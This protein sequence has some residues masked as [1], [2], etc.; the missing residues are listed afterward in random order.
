MQ[1]DFRNRDLVGLG[2]QLQRGVAGLETIVPIAAP[3]K[4]PRDKVALGE[5]SVP[6][7]SSGMPTAPPTASAARR[8]DAKQPDLVEAPGEFGA[9]LP[10]RLLHRRRPGRFAIDGRW[11]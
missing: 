4:A 8:I 9:F 10:H 3:S 2:T 7:T 1:A 5:S 11:H 6:P